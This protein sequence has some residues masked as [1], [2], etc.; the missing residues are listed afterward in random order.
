[1]MFDFAKPTQRDFTETIKTLAGLSLFIIAD[2]TNPRCSP[3]ELQAT[4][5]DY[6]VPFVPILQEDE[7]PFGMFQDL[8][9]KYGQWVLDLLTYDTGDNLIKVLEEAVVKPALEKARELELIKAKA[10]TVRNVN[11]YLPG[12]IG[13]VTD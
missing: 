10:I 4:V 3:L 9:L 13:R 7:E 1:M 11:D 2:I 12:T 5:P 8:K 6:M